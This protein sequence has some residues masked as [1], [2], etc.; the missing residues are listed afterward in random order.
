MDENKDHK[1][2]TCGKA[3]SQCADTNNDH[4]C[5]ICG[6]AL[7]ECLDENKD[8]KCDT[9]G[10]ALSQC[11]D[12]NNDHKCDICGK[13]LSQC[14]D[15]DKNHRCDTCGKELSVHIF[16]DW[17]VTTPADYVTQGE[18]THTCSVCKETRT[19]TIPSILQQ[20]QKM[21]ITAAEDGYTMT[22]PTNRKVLVLLAGYSQAGQLQ[23]IQ[24]LSANK[25][26]EVTFTRPDSEKAMLFF[27][28][29]DYKP[30]CS[31]KVTQ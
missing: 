2:D 13:A 1:C 20:L 28:Q 19:E 14:A 27:L 7:S 9:C 21:E 5:D 16:G 22:L 24:V 18:K 10:K 12:T 3:L 11:A 8:H 15:N 17:S 23:S 31:R 25:T 4:K 29:E 26:G 6:K 30:L